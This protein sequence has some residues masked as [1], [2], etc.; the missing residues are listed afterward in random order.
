[1]FFAH[2]MKKNNHAKCVMNNIYKEIDKIVL[3]SK[4][5][6]EQNNFKKKQ[7]QFLKGSVLKPKLPFKRI[8]L[9]LERKKSKKIKKNLL[10]K[11]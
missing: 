9:K 7:L 4:S 8:L 11:F 1:M 5:V 6:R 2:F 10:K 3:E